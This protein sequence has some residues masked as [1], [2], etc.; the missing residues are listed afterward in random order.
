MKL[1]GTVATP[2]GKPATFEM[3][4]EVDKVRF[5]EAFEALPSMRAYAPIARFL[6]GRFSTNLKATGQLGDDGEPT[7]F[8]SAPERLGCPFRRRPPRVEETLAREGH[9]AAETSDQRCS[10]KGSHGGAG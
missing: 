9:A 8:G 6:D 5:A 2:V 3:D 4:Y 10:E 7:L 1:S